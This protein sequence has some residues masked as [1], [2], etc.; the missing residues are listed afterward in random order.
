MSYVIGHRQGSDPMLL[1]LWCRPA[2]AALT[3]LLAWE[4]PYAAGVALKSK[5]KKKAFDEL[6]SRLDMVKERT[7]ELKDMSIET[8]KKEKGK[9]LK[10]FRTEYLKIASQL[11]KVYLVG[12]P[13]GEDKGTEKMFE[14]I[15]TE[16]LPEL[17]TD[18]I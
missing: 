15:M 1:W 14:V 17:I 16:N 11:Q 3:G 2:A 6:I 18:S 7:S 13:E 4:L 10:K 9:K 5:G 8:S 12:I